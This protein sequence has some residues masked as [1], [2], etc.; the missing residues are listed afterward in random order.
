MRAL[1]WT[2]LLLSTP[3]WKQWVPPQCGHL[4]T[5][6]QGISSQK[7]IMLIFG[8]MRFL[9]YVFCDSG[10]GS[11]AQRDEITQIPRC[12]QKIAVWIFK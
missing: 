9:D 7:I 1:A 11:G 10:N 3:R 2:R 6:L 8:G 4:T 12:S 5:K